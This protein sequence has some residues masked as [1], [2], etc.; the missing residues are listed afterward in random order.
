MKDYWGHVVADQTQ[1]VPAGQS[2]ITANLGVLP[3]GHYRVEA[4]L[5]GSDRSVSGYFA[6]VAALDDRQVLAD[7]PF[8]MDTAASWLVPGDKRFDFARALKLSGITWV[9]DRFRWNDKVNPAPETF[10]FAADP[11][12]SMIEAIS[13]E[14]IHLLEMYAGSPTWTRDAAST[15][16]KDLMAAYRFAK[17][18]AD[19][20]GDRVAAWEVWNEQNHGFTN[21]SEAADQYAAFLKAATIGYMDSATK[22]M[23]AMGGLAYLPGNYAKLMLQNEIFPYIDPYNFHVHQLYQANGDEPEFP[24]DVPVHQQFKDQFGGTDKPMWITE[25]GLG[26]PSTPP[27]ELTEE[28][29]RAQARYL[30]ASAVESLSQGT[31][32]HFIFVT[33][34]Y[35]EGA[36]YWGLFSRAF[37]PY[38]SYAAVSAMTDA[39]GRGQYVGRPQGLPD[40]V[41][42]HAFRD[43]SDSVIV[44][45]SST[46]REVR[47]D[48]DQA[49]AAV[50][51]DLMGG[52]TAL[53]PDANGGYAVQIGPDPVYVRLQGAAGEAPESAAAGQ[54]GTTRTLTS[55]ERVVLYQKYPADVLANSKKNGYRLSTDRATTLS[56]EVYNFNDQPM[57]GVVEGRASGGWV[58]GEPSR[59]VTVEPFGKSVVTFAVYAGPQV[60]ANL[61]SPIVFQGTF[62]GEKTTKSVAR[63]ITPADVDIDS[64]VPGADDPASWRLDLPNAISP[65]GTGTIAAGSE[66]GSVQFDYSFRDGGDRWAYPFL[67]LPA[68]TDYRNY[69]GIAFELYA[70]QDMPD[71][72]LRLFV[73]ESSG[74]RYFT[75]A[76]YTIKQGWNQIQAPFGDFSLFG[77]VDPNLQLDPDRIQSLQLGINARQNDVPP[78][79]IK[80]FGV[81]RLPVDTVAPVTTAALSPAR[82]DGR[83]GSYTGPVTVSLSVYDDGSG[84]SESVYSLSGG[85]SWQAYAGPIAFD[86]DGSYSF[87]YKS[88]DFAGNEESVRTLTFVIDSTA[89]VSLDS[90]KRLVRQYA[91][92]SWIDN[93]GIANSLTAKLDRGNVTAF[94]H[95]VRAQSGKHIR[96]EAAD[97][98]L[99]DAALLAARGNG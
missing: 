42:G 3:I 5:S 68:G 63:V 67:I 81:Y 55:A 2:G 11:S 22:P 33:P 37:A 84:V 7:G 52:K 79:A 45:W 38:A 36:N 25:A 77:G 26:V 65:V 71:T 19:Y 21:D 96:A 8:A 90:L 32:K 58:L 50:R 53:A 35:Q 13:A 39:L 6:V 83:D 59:S 46:P 85:A 10:D 31:S 93:R 80:R 28:E 64:P 75:Q 78:F 14:G 70:E 92:R 43:G 23:V 95:E 54:P 20:Y 4:A 56:L 34:P 57:S 9:R 16:P 72:T 1:T 17:Q 40:S 88:T 74:A 61:S 60:V 29:Q 12:K 24:Q 47:L 99:R 66:P 44:L 51:I 49:S 69:T 62:N 30:V 98:L 86:R 87:S 94:V 15:M 73:N 18:S 97:R 91:E 48:G 41:A 89:T 82:P 76:G 27:A